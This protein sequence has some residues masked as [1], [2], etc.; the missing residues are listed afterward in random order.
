MVPFKTNSLAD[1]PE[2]SD[3]S[4]YASFI[5]VREVSM[6]MQNEF[7]NKTL[8]KEMLSVIRNGLEG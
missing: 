7:F 3:L 6:S 1:I 4:Q 8:A 5:S 2:Y